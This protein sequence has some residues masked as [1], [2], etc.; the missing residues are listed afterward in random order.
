MHQDSSASKFKSV[1]QSVET[2]VKY[3]EGKKRGEKTGGPFGATSMFYKGF[4][5][6]RSRQ[7]VFTVEGLERAGETVGQI[8]RAHV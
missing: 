2:K 6:V 5:S 7:V 3:R 1:C 8:G 4:N